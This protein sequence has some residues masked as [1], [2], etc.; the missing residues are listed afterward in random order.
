MHFTLKDDDNRDRDGHVQKRLTSSHGL[1]RWHCRKRPDTVTRIRQ[2][3]VSRLQSH[4]NVCS[5]PVATL[6]AWW[7]ILDTA[8]TRT[9]AFY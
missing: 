6:V 1:M 7:K 3:P 2:L 8:W 9:L 5:L 4:P